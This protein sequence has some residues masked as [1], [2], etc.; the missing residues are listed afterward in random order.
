[1]D[2]AKARRE[3]RW[4]AR[5]DTASTLQLTADAARAAGVL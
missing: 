5:H 2:T 1:M 4:R 3:L